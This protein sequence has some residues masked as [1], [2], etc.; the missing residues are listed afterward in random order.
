MLFSA[1]QKC[2][3]EFKL[4]L[5]NIQ[6]SEELKPL[7]VI[8]GY[9]HSHNMINIR[10]SNLLNTVNMLIIIGEFY[11]TLSSEMCWKVFSVFRWMLSITIDKYKITLLLWNLAT[12]GGRVVTSELKCTGCAKTYFY[13]FSIL[14]I[15]L[16]L[17]P[18]S[19]VF[20]LCVHLCCS[21]GP[22][23]H[24]PTRPRSTHPLSGWVRSRVDIHFPYPVS[25]NALFSLS[26]FLNWR[27]ECVCVCAWNV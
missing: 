16:S 2:Y 11:H 12:T 14:S 24:L 25:P 6:I 18:S 8:T 10:K 20:N 22:M 19:L 26:L 21:M 5:D 4:R 3:W 23:P 27:K 13:I 9:T 1:K 7:K 15:S 17:S